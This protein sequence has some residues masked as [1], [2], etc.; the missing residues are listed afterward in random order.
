MDILA[1]LTTAVLGA[2]QALTPLPESKA[3]D[4]AKNAIVSE[5]DRTLPK[6]TFA[7]WLRDVA[8]PHA[9]TKWEVNDCGEQTGNPELDKGRD[10]P[11]CVQVHVALGGKRDLYLALAVG[12][13]KRGVTPGPPS[14]F[15]GYVIEAAGTPK[16]LKNLGQ[17]RAAV[18]AAR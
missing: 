1:L 14:F 5:V 16:W 10:F 2:S 4:A 7:R 17:V 11:M 8:G 12:T 15:Y 6:T 3:I 18:R 9:E 13:F